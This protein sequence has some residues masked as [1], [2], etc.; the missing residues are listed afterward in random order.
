MRRRASWMSLRLGSVR[1]ANPEHLLKY[2]S[3]R[4]ERVELSSLH[5]VEQAPQLGIVRHR[6]LEML[7]RARRGDREHLAGEVA[8]PP[9]VELA[10]LLEVRPVRFDLLPQLA[11][12]LAAQRIRENDRHLPF[13]VA[14]ERENRA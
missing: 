6:R 12:A 8:A 3:H 5:L 11:D 14:V 1:V 7:L 4:R 9:R 10:R 13:P 2:L